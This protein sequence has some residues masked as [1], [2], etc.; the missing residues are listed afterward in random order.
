[1]ST[2]EGGKRTRPA[3]VRRKRPAPAGTAPVRR[4]ATG[5]AVRSAPARSAPA[6]RPKPTE[7]PRMSVSTY[8]ERVP[9]DGPGTVLMTVAG[10]LAAAGAVLVVVSDLVPFLVLD[11]EV[12]R[13][14]QNGWSVL[15]HL[16]L[17][18]VGV[19]GGALLVLGRG[20]R[21]GLAAIAA[22]CAV[23]PGNLLLSIFAGS[24]PRSHDLAEYY[25]GE[26][27]TTISIDGRLGRTLA[28]A[29]WALLC[30][31]GGCAV[32]A[33]RQ[34]AERDLIPLGP[35][36]RLAVGAAGLAVLLA[37]TALIVP[38]ALTAVRKYTDPSGLVLTRDLTEPHA[39]IGAG[40]LGFVGGL[41]LLAGW[42]VAGAV[43]GSM[44]SRITVVAALAGLAGVLL[45]DAMLNARDVT[46]GADLVAGPRL[47]LLLAAALVAGGAAA[48]ASRGQEH[49]R[50]PEDDDR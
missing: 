17:L 38:A 15:A 27:H 22:L 7:T 10:L 11:G 45:H 47:Y 42:L 3:V 32:A 37:V 13:A 4:P 48:Y 20:G 2:S 34:I 16:L 31:A 39:T 9:V 18:A 40:G 1:M 26:L 5:A 36:R 19:G 25:F 46:V 43:V 50:A 6:R 12:V 30:L 14:S 49:R 29:G 41:V 24:D 23:A 28:V 35:R 21:V 44:T 8:A 33:W